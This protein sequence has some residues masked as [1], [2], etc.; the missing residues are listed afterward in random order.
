[1]FLQRRSI[2][3]LLIV[4]AVW[5]SGCHSIH[6]QA[7]PTQSPAAI[8]EAKPV[9]VA[10]HAGRDSALSVYNNPT[11]GISFRYPRNYSLDEAL[12]SEEPAILEAQ[13]ELAAEQPAATLVALVAIPP[14][15]YPNTTFRSGTLQFAVNAAVSPDVC[16]S[17]AVPL[18][19]T[20][21]FGSTSIQGIDFSWR[22]RS[23]ATA[24][25]GFLNRDYAGFS[26]GTCYEFFL[27]IVTGSNPDLDP[28]IKD[29]DEVKIMRRLDKIVN[30]LQIHPQA[31]TVHIAT[32]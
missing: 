28:G 4:S 17:L 22:Q 32:P 21:A 1:M 26:N 7:A 5:L 27:E 19:G 14:D 16:Q 9:P 11:Y 20:Y 12:D 31:H 13:G 8:A 3:F 25:T 6:A 23:W 10:K 29:A 15:A 18:D 2:A 24:G 30:S